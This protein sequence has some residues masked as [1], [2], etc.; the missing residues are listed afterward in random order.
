MTLSALLPLAASG[1]TILAEDVRDVIEFNSLFASGVDRK[2]I[3]DGQASFTPA[4]F[5]QIPRL[6]TEFMDINVATR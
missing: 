3:A 6:Y 4:F 2:L 1:A 5:H